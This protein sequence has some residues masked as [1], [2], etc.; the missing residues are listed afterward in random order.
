MVREAFAGTSASAEARAG[1]S[2][3]PPAAVD[4]LVA[5]FG[6]PGLDA[7]VDVAPAAAVKFVE[8]LGREAT[9]WSGTGAV[10]TEPRRRAGRHPDR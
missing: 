7:G 9:I 10:V 2:G 1:G 4:E 8:G 5:P 3:G 6:Y